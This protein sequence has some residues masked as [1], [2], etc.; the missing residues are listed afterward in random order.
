MTRII[1]C[2]GRD[3]SDYEHFRHSMRSVLSQYQDVLLVSG[4]AKGADTLAERF[5]KEAGIPIRVFPA[6]WNKYGKAA[7]PIRNKQM[8]DFAKEDNPVVV[9]FWDGKSRGTR[10]MLMQAGEAGIRAHVFLYADP[11]HGERDHG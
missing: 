4:H 3:F 10:N 11:H 7:G 5:A 8:L 9:A 1:V 2:G 6:D